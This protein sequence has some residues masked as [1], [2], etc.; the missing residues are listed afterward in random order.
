MREKLLRLKDENYKVFNEK[1]LPNIN[2]IL[3]VRVPD[4]RKLAKELAK[5]NWQKDK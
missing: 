5:E 4:L 3:G 2:N 1:L